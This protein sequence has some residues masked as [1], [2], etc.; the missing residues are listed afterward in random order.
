MDF[1]ALA[2][3]S[4]HLTVERHSPGRLRLKLGSGAR[5]H[6]AAS[7]LQKSG[8]EASGIRKTRLNVFTSVLTVEYDTQQLPFE[9][10]DALLRCSSQEQA[11]QVAL[12]IGRVTRTG[13]AH[14]PT[15]Q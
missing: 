8:R 14:G 3:L 12:Q 1:T 7:R 10:L 6:P 5:K 11:H 2:E 15:E 13:C 4:S 9:L